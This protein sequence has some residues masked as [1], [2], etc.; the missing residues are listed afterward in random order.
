MLISNMLLP[1]EQ[2]ISS[3]KLGVTLNFTSSLLKKK[4]R[5]YIIA[6]FNRILHVLLFAGS[7]ALVF[8]ITIS[9]VYDGGKSSRQLLLHIVILIALP[10]FYLMSYALNWSKRI[11]TYV[12][13]YLFV[14]LIGTIF[15]AVTTGIDYSLLGI[16]AIQF[17]SINLP[18]DFSVF[19][20][21]TAVSILGE[22]G[23]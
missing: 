1:T 17:L 3:E 21:F 9:L 4:F 11:F 15:Y 19:L 14:A 5:I 10:V 16:L 8:Y 18:V 6:K 7:V 12:V 20:I 22:V 2:E 23:T 13:A